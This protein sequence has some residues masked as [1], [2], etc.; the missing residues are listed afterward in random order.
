MEDYKYPLFELWNGALDDLACCCKL[1][2]SS[3]LLLLLL[4]VTT[5][6][7]MHIVLVVE[8]FPK[9]MFNLLYTYVYTCM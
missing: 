9:N 3:L 1:L 7:I 5:F 6:R 4:V 8:I 2:S